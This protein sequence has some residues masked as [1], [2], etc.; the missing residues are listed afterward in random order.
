MLEWLVGGSSVLLAAL[1][2]DRTM[3]AAEARGWIYW[4]KRH[5]SRETG[6]GALGEMVEIFKP[7]QQL[8][9]EEKRRQ[10][11]GAEQA[12]ADGAIDLDLGHVTL[13]PRGF[14]EVEHRSAHDAPRSDREEAGVQPGQQPAAGGR[15]HARPEKPS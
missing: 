7:T 1:V 11:A 13:V 8:L 5:P 14:G 12:N 2:I 6:S 3:L 15:P 4:R 10:D 9:Q